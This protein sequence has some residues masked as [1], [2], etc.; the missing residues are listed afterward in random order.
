M[1]DLPGVLAAASEMQ[2][3]CQQNGWGFC[4]I[5]GVAV[6]RWGEPRFTQD[7]DLTLLTGFGSEEIFIS[8][9]LERLLPR[10]P[11]AREFALR[12]RVLLARTRTGVNVDVALGALP[13]EERTVQ[14]ASNWV[15]AEGRSLITCSAEDL[16]VHKVFAGRELDWGDIERVLIRQHGKLDLNLVRSELEPLLE[17]KG[18]LQ[19]LDKLESKIATVERRLRTKP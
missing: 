18:E 19:A 2:D 1:I 12:Q 3:F 15:W 7:V 13:F 10:R 9:L 4:F 11:D 17:L 14:R 8:A 16:V 6:Q 5:G